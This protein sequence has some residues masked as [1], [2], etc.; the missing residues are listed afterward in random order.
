VEEAAPPL[1]G[2][3]PMDAESA[4]DVMLAHASRQQQQRLTTLNHALLGL[5]RANR[6]L[7]G[8]ALRGRQR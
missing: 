2:G 5:R 8:L 7:D 6:C 1:L 3:T 4:S